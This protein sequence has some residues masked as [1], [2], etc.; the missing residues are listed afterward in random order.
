MAQDA[1]HPGADFLALLDKIEAER[2]VSA[3]I[4]LLPTIKKHGQ[5][6]AKRRGLSLSALTAQF[7]IELC[8][9]DEAILRRGETIQPFT[10]AEQRVMAKILEA[11]LHGTDL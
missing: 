9:E 3:G 11:S 10:Q 6:A 4:S 8:K 2:S 5:N 1:P 7:L